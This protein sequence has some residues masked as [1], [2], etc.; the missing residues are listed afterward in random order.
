MC[1]ILAIYPIDKSHPTGFLNRINTFEK[2]NLGEAWRCYKLHFRDSDHLNSIQEAKKYRFILF[3]GHGGESHLCGS[4]ATFGEETISETARSENSDYYNYHNYINTSN[5]QE[6]KDKI[7]CSFSC[8][9]NR[10]TAKSLARAAIE[11]GVKAFIGFGDIP[12]DYVD[13]ETM[14]KRCIAIYKGIIIRIMKYALFYGIKEN[15]TVMSFVKV[16][17]FLTTKEI[18]MLMKSKSKIRNKNHILQ[19]LVDFKNNIR[20][21]GEAH[22]RLCDEHV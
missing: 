11:S 20:I 4:C 14:S 7:F 18:Q 15:L 5:I 8:N 9:S 13:G 22:A 12:T 10:N 3:M 2:R 6:F 1:K 19:Q 16:I 21:M 17:K